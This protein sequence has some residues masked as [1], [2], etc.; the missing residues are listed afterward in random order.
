MK[1]LLLNGSPRI[2]GNTDTALNVIKEGFVQN[3]Q[4]EVEKIDLIDY[5]IIGCKGCNYC[6]TSNGICITKDD[7]IVL[8]EKLL[9]A[10]VVIFG[11]PV[12]WWGISSQLKTLIDRLYMKGN[13][14]AK[15]P[16]KIGIV[17]IGARKIEDSEYQIIGK[18]FECICEHLSWNLLIKKYISASEKTDLANDKESIAQLKEL[19]KK[20]V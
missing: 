12:Y 8:A 18:Q 9:E 10:D 2:G 19:Y 15:K 7:G 16:K 20:F 3:T 4:S 5:N 1:V 11:S 14:L 17:A 6:K 13:F